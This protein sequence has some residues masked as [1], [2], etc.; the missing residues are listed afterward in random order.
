MGVQI[1]NNKLEIIEFK[2]FRTDWLKMLNHELN[3]K[4]RI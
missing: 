3:H 1:D 4:S 2:T